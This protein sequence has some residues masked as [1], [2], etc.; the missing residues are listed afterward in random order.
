LHALPRFGPQ[1]L[2]TQLLLNYDEQAG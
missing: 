2:G 1:S